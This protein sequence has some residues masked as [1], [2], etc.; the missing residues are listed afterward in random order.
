MSGRLSPAQRDTLRSVVAEGRFDDDDAVELDVLIWESVCDENPDFDRPLT[1]PMQRAMYY[2]AFWLEAEISNGGFA[3]FFTN[4]GPRV[5]SCARDFLRACGP[6]PV[7]D[8][9]DRAIAIMP[10]RWRDADFE[11]SLDY[12][13]CEQDLVRSEQ[14]SALD[15]EFYDLELHPGLA[16][17]RLRF[18]H[19]HADEFF[20]R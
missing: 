7:L 1:I 17:C 16:E 5:A 2:A 11:E 20:L 13:L 6:A 4:K 3:Q 9:L 8:L 12:F 15:A 19:A 18:A 10:E 14:L